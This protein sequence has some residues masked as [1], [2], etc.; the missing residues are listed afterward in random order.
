MSEIVR[1]GELD[2]SAYAAPLGEVAI[3]GASPVALAG[4]PLEVLRRVSFGENDSV[5]M[6]TDLRIPESMV[7][8]SLATAVAH[9]A[10]RTVAHA[11]VLAVR[12]KDIPIEQSPKDFRMPHGGHGF[13]SL[14]LDGST[15]E[16]IA[17]ER[18]Q[19][20]EAAESFYRKLLDAFGARSAPHLAL[21]AFALGF[22]RAPQVVTEAKIRPTRPL[23]QP[24]REIIEDRSLG[25]SNIESGN[26][27]G[28]TEG[29]QKTYLKRGMKKLRANDTAHAVA[30]LIDSGELPIIIDATDAPRLANR[31]KQVGSLIARGLTDAQISRELHIRRETVKTYVRR[32]Y[33]KIGVSNRSH[34]VRR[35]YELG[36]LTRQ[37]DRK[38][39]SRRRANG[40]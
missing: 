30:L 14:L 27:R 19:D 10:A 32:M 23:T 36:I 17:E 9:Y 6:A 5:Q 1:H 2:R 40:G 22:R 35:L 12:R 11:T 18:Y 39:L 21:R 7:R 13:L 31:E 20:I 24:Q 16:E 28:R 26:K 25:L 33:R 29:T 34:C 4:L 8:A 3:V 15:L 38:I 37:I